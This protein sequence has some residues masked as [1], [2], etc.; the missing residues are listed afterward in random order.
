MSRYATVNH[1]GKNYTATHYV[2]TVRAV[3]KNQVK[4]AI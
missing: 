2:Y 1:Y 3:Q 4:S